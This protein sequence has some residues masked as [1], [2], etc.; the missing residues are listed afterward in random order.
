MMSAQPAND[1]ARALVTPLD[2]RTPGGYINQWPAA[3]RAEQDVF[4]ID[5]DE[6][7][8]DSSDFDPIVSLGSEFA[9]F[10]KAIPWIERETQL[11]KRLLAHATETETEIP[12]LGVCFGSQLLAS[13]LGGHS[14]WSEMA[15]IGWLPV[16]TS[17]PTLVPEGPCFQWHFDKLMPPPGAELIA[18]SPVGP[19]AFALGRN[20]AVQFHPEV[21][22]QI[23]A[24]W[25]GIYRHELDREGLNPARLLEETDRRAADSARAALRLFDAFAHRVAR[26]EKRG[27]PVEARQRPASTRP[28]VQAIES[29]EGADIHSMDLHVGAS[30][31]RERGARTEIKR[32]L[33]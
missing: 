2:Q 18:D 28:V 24:A 13:V 20:L 14:F 26:A 12:I 9:A 4:R 3:R 22:P 8:V 25:V 5:V 1:R 15:E 30:E 32:G 27:L 7:D 17:N 10:D 31:Q 19:Q 16:R 21:T 11:L 29:C 23:I 33:G 6:R